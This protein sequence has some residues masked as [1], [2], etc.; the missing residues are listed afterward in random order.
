MTDAL[1]GI[2]V[3]DLAINYAGPT[4]S[5]YLADH[6]ADVIKVERRTVGDTSRRSGNTP[7]LKLNSYAFMAI[8]RGKR[9]ITLDISKSEGQ[10]VLRDLV[11]GADVLVENFRPGVMER[12]GLGYEALSEINPR[13]VYASLSAYGSK[14]PL[15]DQAGFDGLAQGLA[16]A[17][18]KRD[19]QGRPQ[20]TG[21]WICDWGA[22]MLMALGI[23]L[24][25]FARDRTGRG[26]RVETSLLQAALAM[27]FS[28]L[29]LVPNNPT[30]P[31]EADSAA[32]TTYRCAD[33]AYVN[34]NVW[35]PEQFSRLCR[36]L[37][38]PD[39]ADDPRN[40]DPLRRQELNKEF[41]PI[42]EALMANRPSH[43]WLA[44][45]SEADIPCAPI[46]DRAQVPFQE[47]VL[48]NEMM[49]TIDHPVV[50]ETHIVGTPLRLSETPSVQLKAAPTLG[51]HTAEIL[52]ALGY[53][54]ERIA[55]LRAAEVI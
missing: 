21:I 35:L 51:Q 10:E 19:A 7:F 28:Q 4:S 13:L 3:L 15:A 5:T 36:T 32:N 41:E 34:I 37:D 49:V 44:I 25:L 29:T 8:N 45:L 6:G 55:A 17:M 12:H 53:P 1:D 20:P 47:Q 50:G 52:G 2:K 23:M 31:R 43:E 33:G 27:Q 38:L 24:A 14:G 39:L 30:P 18:Y 9:S 46:I 16:G 54:P 42:L 22:P 11:R 40:L 26:Q 48:A